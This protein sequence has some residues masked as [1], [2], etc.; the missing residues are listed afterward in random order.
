MGSGSRRVAPPKIANA[1]R[2]PYAGDEA[3]G[4]HWNYDGA[5]ADAHHRECRVR[6]RDG[7]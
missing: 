1:I 5:K 3:L 6:V 7:G 2:Q 4:E